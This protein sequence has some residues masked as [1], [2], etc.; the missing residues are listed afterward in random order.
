MRFLA[1]DLAI[2][3]VTG[4]RANPRAHQTPRRCARQAKA[5]TPPAAFRSTS[6]KATVEPVATACTIPVSLSA[7]C[8]RLAPCSMFAVA[9]GYLDEAPLAGER[10]RL[11]GII[12]SLQR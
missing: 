12:Y 8:A 5:A 4:L 9:L 11:C 10:D 6:A 1:Y 3:L 2:D 7:A